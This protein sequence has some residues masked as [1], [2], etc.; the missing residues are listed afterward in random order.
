MDAPLDSS[1]AGRGESG[2][3]RAA[4]RRPVEALAADDDGQIDEAWLHDPVRDP[5]SG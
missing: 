1:G 2:P 3:G 4:R 5:A